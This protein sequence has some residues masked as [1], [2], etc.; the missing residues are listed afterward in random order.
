MNHSR[1][2]PYG[3]VAVA[4]C[5][6][7]SHTSQFRVSPGHALLLGVH[8]CLDGFN[9]AVFSRHADRIELLL[10]EKARSAAPVLTIDLGSTG[11]RTGDVWHALVGGVRWG[12]PYAYRAYGPWS[13]Q[14]GHRF[15]GKKLLVDPC[16]RAITTLDQCDEGNPFSRREP[17]PTDARSLVIERR[18]DWQRILRPRTPWPETVIYETHVRGLTIHPSAQVTQPG[19]FLGVIEKIPHF[20]ELGVTAVELMP[21]AAF[22]GWRDHRH[23]AH[24]DGPIRNYWGYDTIAFFAP[25][26]LYATRQG[27]GDEVPE[28]KTMVRELH[29]AGIEVILDMVFNHTAEGGEDGPT[30]CFRGLDNAVWY[31]RDESLGKYLNF[32]GCGN[33]LNCNHPVVR[34]YII[35]CLRYWVTEMHV[36]G[37]RFD[38]ASVLGRDEK[39]NLVENAP[40]LE[41]IAEDPILRDVKLIAEAWD[42]GGAYQVGSFPGQR[43][44]EWNGRFRDDVRRFW[45]GDPGMTGTFASRL[46]GSADLYQRSGKEPVNSINFITCHDGLTLNDIVS[47][48]GKHNWC[49]GAA[50]R[51]GND[52][53][54]SMNYGTE[55]QTADPATERNRVQHIKNLLAT[56]FL[57]RGV[58]MLLGGDEFRRTQH[59]N[60]NAWCQDNALSWYDWRMLEANG[61]IFRFVREIIA[62]RRRHP[63][64]CRD[65]FYTENDVRWFGPQDRAPDWDGPTR[66]LG[67]V[68]RQ[69]EAAGGLPSTQS[70]CLL[71][72]ASHSPVEW[73]LPPG[74]DEWRVLVD[75]GSDA[76]NDIFA[77]ATGLRLRNERCFVLGMHSLAVL[78]CDVSP[79]DDALA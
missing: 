68:I 39:G 64:L 21:V 79:V 75:T 66:A 55:G 74:A 31:M 63:V 78:S 44:A 7:S 60:N 71:F 4:V 18:F 50:N 22:D 47:Y 12:Q 19:T 48:N 34:D 45:R 56:L 49:N 30:F 61:E 43:W 40:L 62:L 69:T 35:D 2:S 13:P 3:E 33:T 1:E 15:D 46:C 72:N 37:F 23:E 16:A 32:S 58:P 29:R 9:F 42:L 59:G 26:G 17:V 14:E 53:N 73:C 38:L 6:S 25:H 57:S 27:F 76:P 11:H 70:L 65:A 36:D 24:V 67:C 52:E 54:Y 41:R 5:E 77:A 51:D 10:F 20:L 8:D 28:F